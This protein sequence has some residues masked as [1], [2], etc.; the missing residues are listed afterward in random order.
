M[1]TATSASPSCSMTVWLA[2]PSPPYHYLHAPL[3]ILRVVAE[4]IS[5]LSTGVAYG[6]C[7]FGFAFVQHDSLVGFACMQH[8]SLVGSAFI[9]VITVGWLYFL[10]LIV[11]STTLVVILRL[12]PL[13]SG[14]NI[15]FKQRNPCITRVSLVFLI[16]LKIKIQMQDTTILSNLLF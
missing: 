16:K 2:S 14:E 4:S 7:N 10:S 13:L 15:I 5:L 8:D 9:E 12:T 1:D 11:S 6:Y 3:V